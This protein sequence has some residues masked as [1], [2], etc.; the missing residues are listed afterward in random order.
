MCDSVLIM[1]FSKTFR[2]LGGFVY[3]NK[4]DQQWQKSS[5]FQMVKRS[6]RINHGLE[7]YCVF[8]TCVH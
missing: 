7:A 2:N 8:E 1:R 4:I 5:K 6:K 3:H